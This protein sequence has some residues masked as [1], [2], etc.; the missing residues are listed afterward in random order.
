M[1]QGTGTHLFQPHFLSAAGGSAGQ[2]MA[3]VC[4]CLSFPNKRG[5]VISFS[6]MSSSLLFIA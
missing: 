4:V 5:R 6:E 3:F 1:T 2:W